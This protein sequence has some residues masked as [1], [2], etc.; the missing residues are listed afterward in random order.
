MGVGPRCRGADEIDAGAPRAPVESLDH[1][2]AAVHAA[3]DPAV[4]AAVDPAVSGDRRPD[5]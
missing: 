2:D 3:V 4:H 1:P 5:V